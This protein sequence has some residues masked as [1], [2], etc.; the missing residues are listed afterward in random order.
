MSTKGAKTF[1]G[2]GFGPIQSGL[3]L[4]EAY[5]SKNFGRF[6]MAE[7]DEDLVH[8][9]RSNNGCC[10]INVAHKDGIRTFELEGIEI[11]NP[12]PRV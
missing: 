9:V 5:R 11:Y 1:V 7:I 8:A 4:F 10:R 2:F 6:L 12:C 3:F